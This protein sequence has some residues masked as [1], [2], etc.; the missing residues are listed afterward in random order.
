MNIFTKFHEDWKRTVDVLQMVNFWKWALFFTQTLFLWIVNFLPIPEK[1]NT[2]KSGLICTIHLSPICFERCEGTE[3]WKPRAE[4]NIKL[5]NVKKLP[6]WFLKKNWWFPCLI[7]LCRAVAKRWAGWAMAHP[8]FWGFK[9][10]TCKIIHLRHS[11]CFL[12]PPHLKCYLQ[13]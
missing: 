12:A 2:R 4:L 9:G 3:E 8:V 13:L 6:I 1:S 11:F 7:H 10:K 5:V